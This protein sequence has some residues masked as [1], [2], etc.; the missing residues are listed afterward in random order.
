MKIGLSR[1]NIAFVG[2]F[3]LAGY[4]LWAEHAAHLKLAIPFLPYLILLACPLLHI[5]MHGGHGHGRTSHQ[6]AY[7]Q[8]AARGTYTD[9]RREE[10]GKPRGQSDD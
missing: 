3:V 2:F 1:T 9:D 4:L 8:A 6:N 7:H 5:F 10:I